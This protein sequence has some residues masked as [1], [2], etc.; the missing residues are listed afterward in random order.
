M[1]FLLYTQDCLDNKIDWLLV[2]LEKQLFA[3]SILYETCDC[4]ITDPR[5]A[6]AIGLS[7]LTHFQFSSTLLLAWGWILK[8]P[9]ERR[10]KCETSVGMG[11]RE[12]LWFMVLNPLTFS[13]QCLLPPTLQF[14][15]NS[16]EKT[17]IILRICVTCRISSKSFIPLNI[18]KQTEASLLGP[19]H[20]LKKAFMSDLK[21]LY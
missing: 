3:A 6:M 20:Q 8:V 13:V 18:S 11:L 15:R 10:A 1:W 17:Y 16:G 21:F 9:N 2:Y 7:L 19:I 4:F 12:L 14:S 5:I